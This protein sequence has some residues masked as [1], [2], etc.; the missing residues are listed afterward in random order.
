MAAAPPSL[1]G[2]ARSLAGRGI[3]ARLFIVSTPIGNLG[4]VTHRAVEVLR[5]V[6]RILAE[7]TRRTR[8]LCRRYG[9]E[10]PLISAHAHNEQ[11][12]TA[13][14]LD[15]LAAGED[16]ALVSDAGTPLVSD[17]GERMVQG[18]AEAGHDVVPVPGASAVLAALVA[19][20][21]AV[22]PFT[23]YG[24]APRAARA[25]RALIEQ[26]AGL[27]HTTVLFEAPGRLA[28]LLGELVSRCGPDR[29]VCV[30]REITKL[31][32]TFFRGTL[33]EAQAY[34]DDTTVRGEVVVVVA[35]AGPAPPEPTADQV[36]TLIRELLEAGHKPSS[37]AREAAKRAGIPRADAY[38]LA[39]RLATKREGVED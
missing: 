17:P 23:W 35:G 14:V 12:R 2:E 38:K 20:G 39:I 31:H 26:I 3:V 29:R 24:F 30:A 33:A 22:E 6:S 13:Q 15:W 37:A 4:D 25:R 11:A 36:D 19:S 27:P 9:I 5:Q 34:Y 21:I 16:V 8:I 10:T 18:V 7:D 32:E 1:L 28:R